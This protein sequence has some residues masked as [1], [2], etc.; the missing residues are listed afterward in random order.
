MK[1]D[2]PKVFVIIVTYN[3]AKWVDKCLGSLRASELP[4]ETVVIDNRSPD[5]TAEL[6]RTGYPEVRLIESE[7]NLGFGRANNI[8]MGM[9]LREG[10][11]HVLLLNQDAWVEP[12]TLGNLVRAAEADP[13]YGIISPMHLNGAGDALDYR[14][15]IYAAPPH[16]EGLY[17]DIAL[18]TVARRIY[19]CYFVNAAAWLLPRQTLQRVGGFDPIFTHF[20]EDDNFVQRVKYHGFKIGICPQARIYHDRPYSE[21]DL[22]R[23]ERLKKNMVKY[24]NVRD[25]GPELLEKDLKAHRLRMWVYRLAGRQQR[26]AFHRNEIGIINEIRD[27]AT[28]SWRTNREPGPHYLE[29]TPA[30]VK[31]EA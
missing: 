8:G 14:F 31:E 15:S 7:S 12:D 25:K 26:S 10:A 4:V 24:S 28:R 2:T 20:G 1:N 6:V 21:E 23:R 11:D 18:G 16:C 29:A 13:E 17:S 22:R 3:G 9:A 19:P 5:A 27:A 30:P